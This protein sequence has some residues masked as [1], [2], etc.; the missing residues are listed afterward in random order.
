ML[1]HENTE[2]TKNSESKFVIFDLDNTLRDNKGSKHVIPTELGLSMNVA[3]N[4]APWQHYVNENSPTIPYMA[5]FY[6]LMCTT[7]NTEVWI[8]TSSSFGT[9]EWLK[10][11]GLPEPTFIHERSITDNRKP[12]EYKESVVAGMEN[13]IDLW[14][15]DCPRMCNKMRKEGVKVLQVTHNHYEH[16]D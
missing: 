7:P 5:S 4:W 9:S 6:M 15:D 11:Y 13:T 2:T 1:Q 10:K 12:Q 3:A 16:Q 14:V 8:I